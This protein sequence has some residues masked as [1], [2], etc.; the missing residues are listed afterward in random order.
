[1]NPVDDVKIERLDISSLKDEE[2]LIISGEPIGIKVLVPT[3]N[4]KIK[5]FLQCVNEFSLEK[6]RLLYGQIYKAIKNVDHVS[7]CKSADIGNEKALKLW[8]EFCCDITMV[9]VLRFF[10]FNK[11]IPIME[12]DAIKIN[13]KI[14]EQTRPGEHMQLRIS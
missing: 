11:Q 4:G 14:N 10:L 3:C 8:D 6:K 13:K 12:I 7:L 2:E 9:Y 1:M 5:Q